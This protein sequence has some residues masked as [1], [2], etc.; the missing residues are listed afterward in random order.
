[1][2]RAE[3]IIEKLNLSPLPQEGGYYNETYRSTLRISKGALE[4]RYPR[5]R[6]ASTCI[7]YLITEETFSALH[8]I[9]G[10]EIFHFYLL[11]RQ[12]EL[13]FSNSISLHD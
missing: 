4:N 2:V 1:M 13:R 10:D 6:D 8:R 5:D 12:A 11:L 9:I 7:Y 3:D